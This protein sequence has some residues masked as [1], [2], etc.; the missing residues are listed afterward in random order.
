MTVDKEQVKR[1]FQ[2]YKKVETK[3]TDLQTTQL[4]AL[5]QKRSDIIRQIG[6]LIAPNKKVHFE[7][8]TLTLVKRGELWYLRGKTQ[9][10]VLEIV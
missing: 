7:G 8:Q 6:E 10:D 4:N 5:V 1:L 9:Q 3:I 2:E